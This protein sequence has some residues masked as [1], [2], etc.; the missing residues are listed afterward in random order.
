MGLD[1]RHYPYLVIYFVRSVHS[2][3]IQYMYH[4]YI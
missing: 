2:F 4:F 1:N 3:Y